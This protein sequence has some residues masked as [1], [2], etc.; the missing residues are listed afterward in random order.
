MSRFKVGDRVVIVRSHCPERIGEV[1]SIVSD[2]TPASCS[3]GRRHQ[4][5]FCWCAQGSPLL[6]ELDIPARAPH[7]VIAYPPSHL[8]PY[9]DDGSERG[10]WTAELKRLCRVK[11]DA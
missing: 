2:L 10:E 6:H 8:E 9:R 1:A 11:E 3:R 4:R 7:G 5:G